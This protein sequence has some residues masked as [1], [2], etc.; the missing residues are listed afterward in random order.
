MHSLD[1]QKVSSRYRLEA[2]PGNICVGYFDNRRAPALRLASGDTVSI[3]TLNHF[4]DGISTAT[5]TNDVVEFRKRAREYGPHTVTGP[6]FVEDAEP[7]D[8]LAIA[9]G[10]I[11]PRRH[12]YNF[13]MPGKEFP[14]LGALP[15]E[16]PEGQIRHF[17]LDLDRKELVFSRGIHVPLRPFPGIV[18]VSPAERA[19]VSTIAPGEFGGNMD[20]KELTEGSVLLLPVFVE[21]ALLWVGD[22]HA[23]QGDGE[24][25]L[26]AVE[27]AFESIELSVAVV[28]GVS[29]KL[30]R[31]E[32]DSHWITMGF[33]PDLDEAFRIALKEMIDFIVENKGLSRLDA[34]SLASIA[35]DFRITQVVDGNKG[36]HGMLPKN[37]FKDRED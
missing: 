29:L 37:I 5:A 7:G 31:A 13:N 25:N 11:R 1:R 17:D 36:V 15:E 27:C 32:T 9:I 24:V 16:F 19:C 14:V 6:I 4:G 33:H 12:G 26:T 2:T 34:Y 20:L 8:A 30:P 23:A 22:A 21:G 18:A 10:E 35:V 3:E 28:K